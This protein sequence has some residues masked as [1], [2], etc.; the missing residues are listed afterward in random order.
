MVYVDETGVDLFMTRSHGRAPRGERLNVPQPGRKFKRVNIVAGWSNKKQAFV[1]PYVYSWNTNSAWFLVWFEYMLLPLL[2][3]GTLI[4][5]DN[6][7]FHRRKAI[8]Y[9][10]KLYGCVAIFQ[11]KYSPDLN[12]IEKCWANLKRWLR[13]HSK[14]FST[15]QLAIQSRFSV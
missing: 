5:L 12:P 3:P 6:A 9:L 11:P 14:T 4:V 1:A 13:F 7:S 8:E 2:A 15:I 10:A